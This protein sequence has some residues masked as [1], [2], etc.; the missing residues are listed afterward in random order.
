MLMLMLPE[1][2]LH[3]WG[4]SL[5][6]NE[7]SQIDIRPEVNI[8][9]VL[10]HL[11]YKPWFALSEF[12]DNSLSS[13]LSAREVETGDAPFF[14][15][16]VRIEIETGGAG[17]IRIQD[18]AYGISIH[19]FPRAFRAA[20]PPPDRSGLSE[21]G[22][23]MKSAASWFAKRWSV[24]T[25]V[26]G[27]TIQRSV[28]FD[29]RSIAD[30]HIEHLPV[31]EAPAESSSHFT[32][33]ELEDLN[34]IPQGR[35]VAKIRA[36]LASIY[37]KFL[38]AGLMEISINGAPL[39]YSEVPVLRASSAKDPNGAPKEWRKN[40]ISIDLGQGRLVT[41]FAALRET[42]STSE[43]GF[44]LFRR[45]RLIVG[46]HDETYRPV[47][48]F[49]R[50]NSYTYQRL[51]GEFDL[52]GFDVSHTKDGFQWDEY[53][54]PFLE[55]LR[56]Q[57]KGEEF[58]LLVQ[59]EGHRVKTSPV[60]ERKSIESAVDD[61]SEVLKG[62]LPSIVETVSDLPLDTSFIA[63]ALDSTGGEAF[64]RNVEI[65]TDRGLWAIEMKAAFDD[66]ASAWL[67]VGADVESV[68]Q[69]TGETCTRM[70]IRISFAHP[71]SRRYIGANAEN[72]EALLSFG[73]AV[74]IAVALGKRSGARS[75]YVLNFLNTVLRGS[76]QISVAGEGGKS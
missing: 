33:V 2:R 51:F 64:E 42:G 69:P 5:S 25:S 63:R 22:M 30:N 3:L 38:R 53:E 12:V 67:E 46:S 17:F 29:L 13:I 74:A 49:G 35:T 1:P 65:R 45:G 75:Q 26:R 11:N 58:D 6:A 68:Y 36:H 56:S 57:L 72:S 4:K 41:G 62:R 55:E 39:A 61:L 19:D 52:V 73:C 76:F 59:A 43:A 47:E 14:K 9:A 27:E 20:E 40:Q 32:V 48:I 7:L 24:R 34:H 16:Q 66:A 71:F 15:L 10:R 60:D 44:A 28:V 8:L 54:E 23:G 37:R 31:V 18:N 50:S 21:F 70:Q